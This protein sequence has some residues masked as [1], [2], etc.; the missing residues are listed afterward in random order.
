MNDTILNDADQH[1]AT[2]D[3]FAKLE[4]RIG[5]IKAVEAIPESHKL[6]K[7]QVDFGLE[8]GTRQILSG[9]K[10]SYPD[11]DRLIGQS[12]LAIT[13]FPERTMLGEV[14]QGMLL[15]ARQASTGQLILINPDSEKA[16]ELGSLI[17]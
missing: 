3:D 9:I 1:L 10:A 2:I 5:Q 6:L 15:S 13:N 14:S 4:I 17:G 7:F 11:C 8:F 16:I 12:V